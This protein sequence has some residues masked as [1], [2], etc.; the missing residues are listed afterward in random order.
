MKQY[1]KRL[2]FALALVAA[3]IVGGSHNVSAKAKYSVTSDGTL[4]ISGSGAVSSTK[5]FNA[6]A[7][8]K[9]IK[10]IVIKKGIT[11]IPKNAFRGCT[12]VTSI[13]VNPSVKKI[14]QSAFSTPNVKN[15]TIPG[16]FTL[17]K[18][19]SSDE[20][21]DAVCTSKALETVT[22]NTALD[23]KVCTYFNTNNF[24]TYSKDTKF[25]S[26]DGIIY[27]KNGK[28]FV[29]VPYKRKSLAIRE[30]CTDVDLWGLT[31]CIF[32]EDD[33]AYC[34]VKKLTIPKSVVRI[35]NT[36]N[37]GSYQGYE[38]RAILSDITIKSTQLTGKSISV[39]T[40]TF[41]N[42]S[43]DDYVAKMPTELTKSG[44]FYI[45]DDGVNG[46]V[47]VSYAGS[48][49]DVTIPADIKVIGVEAFTCNSDLKTV[50]FPEGLTEIMRYAFVSCANLKA[51]DI[52]AKCTTIGRNAFDEC[53][54]LASINL[55]KVTTIGECAFSNSGVKTLTI[56]A[57]VTSLGKRAFDYSTEAT[58]ITMKKLPKDCPTDLF[59]NSN[60]DLVVHFPTKEADH[61]YYFTHADVYS[62]KYTSK[63]VTIEAWWNKVADTDGYQ[64][65]V[66]T[67]K[68]YPSKY[69]LTKTYKASVSNAKIEKI[70]K[71]G[72]AV[73]M[74]IRPYKTIDGKKVYGRWTKASI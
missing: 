8:N 72:V 1:T 69:T 16:K 14:G 62:A 52:P 34:H 45:A 65:M 42:I 25:K 23:V 18:E 5:Y 55:G 31:Y 59:A 28:E 24:V 6:T 20:A 41:Y 33:I 49:T 36:K 68:D 7:A 63:Y 67:K 40:N 57:T 58:S 71:Q 29:R 74:K 48:K 61:K 15:I 19:A 37:P 46:K 51:I 35:N 2:L 21:L 10:K 66:S 43:L 39:L 56:P 64:V 13:T 50:K 47:L 32:N 26:F 44:D 38:Q 22:F 4:T 12:N 17:V 73:Y 9:K 30:G 27:T 3:F 11:S 70:P 60:E 53:V 54:S